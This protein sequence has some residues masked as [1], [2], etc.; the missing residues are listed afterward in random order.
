MLINNLKK[1]FDGIKIKEEFKN[2]DNLVE[3][4]IYTLVINIPMLI[5]VY[6]EDKELNIDY[7]YNIA[8]TYIDV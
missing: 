6:N 7:I 3:K 2:D 5:K 8:K 4:L 1:I